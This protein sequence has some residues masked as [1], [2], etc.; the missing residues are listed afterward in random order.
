MNLYLFNHS[1]LDIILSFPQFCSLLNDTVT[2]KAMPIGFVCFLFF[3]NHFLR[4]DFYNW[5]DWV[6]RGWGLG[7]MGEGDREIQIS[8][9]K[10]NWPRG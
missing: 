2:M 4:M 6:E 7:N 9:Y 5:D 8:N 3:Y 1:F 10:I